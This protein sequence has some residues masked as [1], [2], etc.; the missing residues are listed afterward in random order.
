MLYLTPK[1]L[2]WIN[3]HLSP[4][5]QI[6]YQQLLKYDTNEFVTHIF[7]AFDKNFRND[8]IDTFGNDLRPFKTAIDMTYA[9]YNLA[10]KSATKIQRSW[11]KYND[12]YY[13]L[14]GEISA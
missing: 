4:I 11:R 1:T 6:R 7:P 8:V 3:Q 10:I 5:F 13:S 14:D 12:S 2:Q 9:D